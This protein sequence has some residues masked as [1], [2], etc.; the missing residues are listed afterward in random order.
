MEKAHDRLASKGKQRTFFVNTLPLLLYGIENV[1]C[2]AA[3]ISMDIP[4]G[5]FQLLD[6][7]ELLNYPFWSLFLLHGQPP[8]LNGLLALILKH[9]HPI[10]TD[11]GA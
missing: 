7:Q 1:A 9:C 5:Y 10:A 8:L 2:N 4:W 6:R 11:F 3:S